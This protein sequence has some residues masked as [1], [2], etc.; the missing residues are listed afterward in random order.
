MVSISTLCVLYFNYGN[1]NVFVMIV[2]TLH[3]KRTINRTMFVLICDDS[4]YTIHLHIYQYLFVIP[5]WEK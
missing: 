5:A 4:N 3:C 2:V 1:C